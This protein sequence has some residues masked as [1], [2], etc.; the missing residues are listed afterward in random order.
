MITI[1][2]INIGNYPYYIFKDIVNIKRFD[3]NFVI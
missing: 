2:Q 3:S 1:K